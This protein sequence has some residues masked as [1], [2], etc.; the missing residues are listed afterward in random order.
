MVGKVEAAMM[1][2]FGL[3]SRV[4]GIWG[5][6]KAELVTSVAATI[7]R[8]SGG[9]SAAC[10]Y[11]LYGVLYMQFRNNNKWRLDSWLLSQIKSLEYL[12]D[13]RVRKNS[14]LAKPVYSSKCNDNFFFGT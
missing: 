12:P 2:P 9:S 6:R 14:I 13:T 4:N 3:R 1:A 8:S 10:Y 5:M 11:R 7:M